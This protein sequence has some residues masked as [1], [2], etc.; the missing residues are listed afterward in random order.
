MALTPE[1]LTEILERF[2]PVERTRHFTHCPVRY[3]GRRND[4]VVEEF[5]TTA[6]FYKE[7]EGI[8]DANALLGLSLLLEGPAHTWWQGI[9]ASITTWEEA[10]QHL[11]NEFAPAS[12]DYKIYLEVFKTRQEDAAATGAFLTK[13][14]ALLAKLNQAQ[15]EEVQL[16][17]VYGL[18]HVDIR[19]RVP[20]TSVQTFDELRTAARNVEIHLQEKRVTT[21]PRNREDPPKQGKKV[22]CTFCRSLGHTAETCRKKKATHTTSE[23]TQPTEQNSIR[24]YGCQ[25][26]GVIRRN[27]PNCTA[28]PDA[29]PSAAFCSLTTQPGTHRPTIRINILGVEGSA[30]LDTGSRAN[31]AR[32]KLH[33]LLENARIPAQDTQMSLYLADGTEAKRTVKW[34]TVDC[35]IQGIRTQTRFMVLPGTNN[36]QTLLGVDFMTDVGLRLLL[37]Q[38]KYQIRDAPALYPF[39]FEDPMPGGAAPGTPQIDVAAVMA[40]TQISNAITPLPATPQDTLMENVYN[41]SIC[42]GQK[43]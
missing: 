31:I 28:Q 25:K 14:R 17:M 2:Q 37:D 4:E 39:T 41:R 20:R 19:D 38:G 11:R 10:T 23:T 29:R 9:K 32:P 40:D 6:T 43:I 12:P 3:G 27:C 16:D 8:T 21:G 33:R 5:I 15:P 22:R 36:T 42:N 35:G 24:C 18:L 26:P 13:K 34:Y 1:A 30:V 7:S